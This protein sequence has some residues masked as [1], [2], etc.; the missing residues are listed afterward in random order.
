M[1]TAFLTC[2]YTGRFFY[3]MLSLEGRRFWILGLLPL[4]RDRLLWGKFAFSA[5]GS[6]LIAEALIILSDLMLGMPLLALA[7]HMLT[8]GVVAVG[9]SGLGVGLGAGV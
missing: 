5:T 8:V 9:L 6:L 1:A 3:P 2:D 4:R 7:V